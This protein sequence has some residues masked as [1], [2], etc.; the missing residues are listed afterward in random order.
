[1]KKVVGPTPVIQEKLLAPIAIKV[2]KI[3]L[4]RVSSVNAI[5][6]FGRSQ[7]AHFVWHLDRS[8]IILFIPEITF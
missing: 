2:I 7:E 5:K 4:G 8:L 6:L 1:L 3:E